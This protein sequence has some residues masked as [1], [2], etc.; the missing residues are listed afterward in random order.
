LAAFSGLLHRGAWGLA[1]QA[2]LS[3]ATFVT[4]ALIARAN[5]VAEFGLFSLAFTFINLE[6]TLAAAVLNEPFAVIS[7]AYDRDRYCALVTSTYLMHAWFGLIVSAG[8]GTFA[9]IDLAAG[10]GEAG[11]VALVAPA[12]LAW[13][14]QDFTRQPLYVE[15][16]VI[17]AFSNDLVGY[18]G[19]I[20][21]MGLASYLGVLTPEVALGIVAGSL[22]AAVLLGFMQLRHSIA[23]RISTREIMGFLT[24]T[25]TCGRWVLGGTFLTSVSYYLQPFV[26]AAFHGAAAAGELRAMMTLMG[27]GRI[28]IRGVSTSFTPM[29]AATVEREGKVGLDALVKKMLLLALPM[30]GIYC[31]IV[32]AQPARLVT[33][34][35]GEDYARS[36][37]WLLPMVALAFFIQ[38]SIIPWDIG[39]RA[40][41][42]TNPLF[43]AGIQTFVAFWVIGVPATYFFGLT[44]AGA[45]AIGVP[46][47]VGL[48]L[49]RNYHNQMKTPFVEGHSMLEVP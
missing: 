23:L 4:L 38:M 10:W 43:R 49:R 16:R 24:E 6:M 33:F 25:W 34:L 30:M 27:P 18:G 15:G 40:L 42:V 2:L 13:Q 14:L 39:L 5:S 19:Q 8:V 22:T 29:A 37:S 11:M 7:A 44:G 28:I 3:L 47:I 1:D 21:G 20:G 12:M 35:F 17:A 9:L 45:V 31:L 32:S 41:R 46:T 26:L 48:E 36:A